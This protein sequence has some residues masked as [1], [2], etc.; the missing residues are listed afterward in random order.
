MSF[1]VKRKKDKNILSNT[2]CD[3]GEMYVLCIMIASDE[4]Y[5]YNIINALY[6]NYGYK[7][8]ISSSN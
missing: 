2:V 5:G 6:D 7:T 4:N 8:T 1:T 3:I